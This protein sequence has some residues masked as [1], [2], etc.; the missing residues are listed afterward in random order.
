MYTH[1]QLSLLCF[2]HIWRYLFFSLIFFKLFKAFTHIIRKVID[3]DIGAISR[4]EV[5][6]ESKN[7][8]GFKML[9]T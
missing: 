3:E 4:S 7:D 5:S 8:M 2:Y 6:L 1:A 9:M